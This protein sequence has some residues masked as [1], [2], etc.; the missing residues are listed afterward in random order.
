[1]FP[2]KSSRKKLSSSNLK[3]SELK[4]DCE[5][6]S[7]LYIACQTRDGD[8]AEFFKFENQPYPPSLSQGGNLRSG[9]K[10]DLLDCFSALYSSHDI[11]DLNVDCYI[12]DG[13]VIVQMLQPNCNSTF[14]DYRNKVFFP[15]V[16]SLMRKV[17][18]IDIVFD[19]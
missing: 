8:L 6:F 19:V 15:F 1:L 9:T 12:L 16:F 5:L 18:R 14:N 7:R 13:A 4:T 3:L 10:S 2:Y 11:A 17:K